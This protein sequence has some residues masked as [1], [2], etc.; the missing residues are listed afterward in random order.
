MAIS[1]EELINL[2]KEYHSL[3]SEEEKLR[4]IVESSGGEPT[5]AQQKTLEYL[6]KKQDE[7]FKR[8]TS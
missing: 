2:Q 8:A 1:E 3:V 5:E 6:R 7:I 4:L